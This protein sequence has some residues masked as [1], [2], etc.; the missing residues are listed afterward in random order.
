VGGA[1]ILCMG[2]VALM[3]YLLRVE[4]FMIILRER[5]IR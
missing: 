2:I 5:G 4:P 3:Y 1:A